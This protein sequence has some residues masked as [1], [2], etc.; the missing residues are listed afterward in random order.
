MQASA[1]ADA[2]RKAIADAN[3]RNAETLK[4]MGFVGR[5]VSRFEKVNQSYL[6]LQTQANDVVSKRTSLSKF[7]RLALQSAILGLVRT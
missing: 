4:A 2:A 5:A 6:A 7:L 3:A 1:R